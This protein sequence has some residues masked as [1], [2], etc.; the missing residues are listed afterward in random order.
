MIYCSN[1]GKEINDFKF[2][3]SCGVENIYHKKSNKIPEESENLD[4]TKQN[5]KHPNEEI[6]IKT[7]SKYNFLSWK[8]ILVLLIPFSIIGLGILKE[9]TDTLNY[10]S[11]EIIEIQLSNNITTIKHPNNLTG[12]IEIIG[13][14]IKIL[15][16]T[17]I[18][19]SCKENG[20]F[21]FKDFR[22]GVKNCVSDISWNYLGKDK[23]TVIV[24]PNRNCPD[25]EK[26]SGIYN[27]K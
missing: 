19:Y 21:Y 3:P 14:F 15:D 7:Y 16:Y 22:T 5:L 10:G 4:L 6:E 8:I 24:K 17:C 23:I 2:C 18:D 27:I 12:E 26:W 1:C 20:S 25:I 11:Y 13:P 9:Y